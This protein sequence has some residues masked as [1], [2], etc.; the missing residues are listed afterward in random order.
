MKSKQVHIIAGPNGSGK[1]TFAIDFLPK[2]ASCRNFINADLIARGLSPLDVDA[3]AVKAGRLFLERIEMQ[4]SRGTDFAFETTL[5]GLSYLRLIRRMRDEAYRINLYFLW[6]PTHR[7]SLKRIAE[8]VR[9]GGHNIPTEVVI[10]R[11]RKGLINLFKHYMAISDYCA[12]FDNTTRP[13][14][15]YE[16]LSGVDHVIDR[17]T[18][19]RIKKQAEEL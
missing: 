2:V 11:F 3:V 5:S 10:R 15:V 18:C 19:D 16:L 6:L 14:L 9:R 13:K 1:T 17:K 4:I 12:I 8:R 7:L